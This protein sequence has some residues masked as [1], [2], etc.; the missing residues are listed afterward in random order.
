MALPAAGSATQ[1]TPHL[2]KVAVTFR[3]MNQH[4]SWQ[5]SDLLDTLKT[6]AAERF[7]AELDFR[8]SETAPT[9]LFLYLCLTP[10]RS[11]HFLETNKETARHYIYI[12]ASRET[13]EK[14]LCPWERCPDI[15]IPHE[16]ISM[17]WF[18]SLNGCIR[19]NDSTNEA[20]VEGIVKVLIKDKLA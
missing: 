8:E 20:E 18:D 15:T 6:V 10:N 11:R 14:A 12:I 16:Q 7:K 1:T 17:L 19:R 3:V 4:R 5:S 13:K 2:Q 9:E